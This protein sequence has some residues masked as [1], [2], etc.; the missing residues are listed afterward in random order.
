[1]IV[2]SEACAMRA[3]LTSA[4]TSVV[5]RVL[6]NRFVSDLLEWICC[7]SSADTCAAFQRNSHH[8]LATLFRP[9]THIV[10]PVP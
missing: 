1:M 5:A 6:L 2:K 9:V 10:I 8:L 7:Q 3:E 4:K